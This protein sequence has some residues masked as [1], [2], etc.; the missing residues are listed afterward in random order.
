MTSGGLGGDFA[1][2]SL[3][4]ADSWHFFRFLVAIFTTLNLTPLGTF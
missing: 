1:T 4:F 3:K 2:K